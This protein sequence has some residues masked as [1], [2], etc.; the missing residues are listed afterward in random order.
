MRSFDF[1]PFYRSTIGFDRL[2]DMLDQVGGV[3]GAVPGY[4]P[5]NI[6]RSAEN[7]YSISVAVAGFTDADLSIEVKENT[8]TIRG[9]KQATAGAEESSEVLYRGIAGRNFERSFQLA[10]HVQVQ[11]ANLEN[12]LLRLNLVRVLPEAM[13][14][15]VIPITR[16]VASVVLEVGSAKIAA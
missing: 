7:T 13:R 12:G 15:R 8:L 10:D 5:Y 6:E 16:P 4:P 11:G 1:A 14:P 3:E 9:E 2:F